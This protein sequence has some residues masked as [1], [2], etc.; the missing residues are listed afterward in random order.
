MPVRE[1]AVAD[2]AAA[3]AVEVGVVVAQGAR[4]L[5]SE[6]RNSKNLTLARLRS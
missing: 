3:A 2:A 6:S 4:R 1:A 5:V